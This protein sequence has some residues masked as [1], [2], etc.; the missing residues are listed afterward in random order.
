MTTTSSARQRTRADIDDAHQWNLGDIYANWAEWE[1]AL[2]ELD[3]RVDEY[4]GLKGT[5]GQGPEQLLA[6]HVLN[7]ELGQLAYRVYYY[8]ALKYDE[9]QRD[10]EVHARKQRVLAL[11]ARWQHATA[12]FSPEL[13]AI[14]LTTIR[15]W[16]D[17]NPELAVYRFSI[18]EVYRQ[19][20]HVLDEAGERLMS[21][22]ARLSG[23]PGD[24]FQALST[25]DAKFPEV[26]F[27]TG[28]TVRMSYG[29]Y[30]AVLATERNQ[31]DRRAGFLGHYGAFQASL[32]TFASLYHGVCQRDWFHARARGYRTTLD[33]ALHG[34]NIPRAVVDNLIA[35]TRAGVEPLRR[36]HRLRRRA[37]QLERYHTYDFSIPIV[38]WTHRYDFDA[39][40]API[41]EAVAPLGAEFQGRMWQGFRQ[42]WIDVYENEGKRSG[43]YSAPVYGVHPYMLLNWTDTLDDVFTLTHEMGHTVHTMLSHEHQPFVYADY[44][45][46]VAEVPST[47]NEALLLEH[48][49][50]RAT[51]RDEQIVLLQHAIDN[52]T[53]T[54]YTQVLFADFELAAHEK[55]ERDEAITAEALCRLYQ[56]RFDAWYGDAVDTDDL[57]NI[58]WARIPHF[59][60]SPYYV[61]Q[62]A[63]CFASA[64]RMAESLTT[65]S[66]ADREAARLR[67]LELLSSGGNDHP[68][69]QLRRAG[70]DL[71]EPSTVQAVVDQLDSL[72]GRLEELV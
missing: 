57:M 3:R 72:V 68:M 36:Y 1:A 61:Y 14:P 37:L 4:A 41:V 5:L 8:P 44:P 71:S 13:L 26:T 17:G 54:F 59:Y 63:T 48:L 62:Y 11:M 67:Y 52:I 7:D 32:N 43:A 18:E 27:S 38:E 21:L 20:E 31:A 50:A 60:T 12:W 49:L 10:N 25:A 30:R 33:A 6:A 2:A 55:V 40:L 9:D 46:F 64:A 16:L 45:I 34:N 29:Q 65:G 39:M 56:E 22:A 42:R 69:S 24:A 47:L 15:Q 19:Q 66:N 53:G 70:I 28:Q 23:A 58:T 51:D 35:T